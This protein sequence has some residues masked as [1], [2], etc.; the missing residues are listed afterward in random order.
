MKDD[1][2]QH[3]RQTSDEIVAI[4][5]RY[6]SSG[7]GLERF[8]RKHGIPAG[9][10]HY[11]LYQKHHGVG[12]GRCT[13][14]ARV[15]VAP[16]F[17]ELKLSTGTPLVESWVAE[18]DLPRGIAVRFSRAATAEWIGSVVRALQRSC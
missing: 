18:V 17:Q 13:K 7:L 1:H 10:L 4:V 11:W 14:P 5:S 8:A 12:P 16:L 2:N 15:A 6:R 3:A 9:R